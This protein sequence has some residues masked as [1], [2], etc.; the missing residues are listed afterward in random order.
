MQELNETSVWLRMARR[1]DPV[2]AR[3]MDE[4][5]DENRQLCRS[6]E[7]IDK[8]SQKNKNARSDSCP[9]MTIEYS[10]MTNDESFF[11]IR[12]KV[13][14]CCRHRPILRSFQEADR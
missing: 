3:Q 14:D 5:I 6:I 9:A 2:K 13:A 8:D 1:A 10:K 12:L 4:L 11:G 7:R